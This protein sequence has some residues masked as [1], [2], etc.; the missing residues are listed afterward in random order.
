MD[1]ALQTIADRFQNF[2][3]PERMELAKSF[4]RLSRTCG[5]PRALLTGRLTPEA[6]LIDAALLELAAYKQAV[7]EFYEGGSRTAWA[8]LMRVDELLA[9]PEN[10][11]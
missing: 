9:A 5:H 8:I 10:E 6:A 7:K 3:L 2:S 4:A 1:D 11:R